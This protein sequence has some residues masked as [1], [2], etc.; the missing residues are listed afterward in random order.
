MVPVLGGKNDGGRGHPVAG[1]CLCNRP[2]LQMG[3]GGERGKKGERQSL[4][5]EEGDGSNTEACC[6]RVEEGHVEAAMMKG[7]RLHQGG[8]RTPNIRVVEEEKKEKND[9]ISNR[10]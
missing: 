10:W 2:R 4:P 6:S 5:P 1:V 8:G 7:R 9:E 3:E